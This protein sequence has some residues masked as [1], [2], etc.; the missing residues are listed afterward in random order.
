MQLLC[1]YCKLLFI[2][3]YLFFNTTSYVLDYE[4][5]SLIRQCSNSYM[6]DME[7]VD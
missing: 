4:I 3:D 1:Q 2:F 6:T 7:G 5:S